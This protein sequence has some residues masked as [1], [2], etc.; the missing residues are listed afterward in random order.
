MTIIIQQIEA[1]QVADYKAIRL[2]ALQN[3]PDAFS[4][5]YAW[6]AAQGNDFHLLRLQ[7]GRVYGAYDQG[8]IVGM[9]GVI[10][11][12]EEKLRHRAAI[13]GVYVSP[14]ARKQGVGRAMMQEALR[15]MPDHIKRVTLGV[16]THNEK[17]IA[18]YKAMG[19]EE[20]GL[21]KMAIALGDK[22][23]DEYLMVKFL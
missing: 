6:E 22:M 10:V 4:S 3:A 2:E 9:I 21:E 11:F 1:A 23:Y 17:A 19:F 7:T 13:W 20:Y 16:G 15:G 18:L 12:P 8:R 5:D 14:D